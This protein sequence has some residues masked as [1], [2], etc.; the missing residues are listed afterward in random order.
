MLERHLAAVRRGAGLCLVFAAAA[1][2]GVREPDLTAVGAA[3]PDAVRA[4]NILMML[5]LP[6]VSVWLVLLLR[7][8]SRRWA[9]IYG[10]SRRGR[11]YLG[12]R[13][14]AFLPWRRIRCVDGMQVH[15]GSRLS[16]TDRNNDT[17]LLMS[18]RSGRRHVRIRSMR[19]TTERDARR[20]R[21][22]LAG[23]GVEAAVVFG[24]E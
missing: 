4:I 17:W 3:F 21:T 13:L 19:P 22:W 9:V 10:Y 12:S 20:L 11:P 8:G 6:A 24:E 15:L 1:I 18:V 16:R 5:A 2:L 23:Q 14:G 7:S